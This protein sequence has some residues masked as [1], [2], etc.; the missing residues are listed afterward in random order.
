VGF[1]LSSGTRSN[2]PRH[3][4]PSHPNTGRTTSVQFRLTV[5]LGLEGEGDIGNLQPIPASSLPF[6]WKGSSPMKRCK[7]SWS[8]S[9]SGFAS[10]SLKLTPADFR[11]FAGGVLSIVQP[12]QT[13]PGSLS[14]V[15]FFLLVRQQ[16]GM[17]PLQD[18]ANCVEPRTERERCVPVK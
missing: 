5:A 15:L 16:V 9:V 17:V 2:H 13:P 11:N 3:T 6:S 18:G 14:G 7:S 8:K 4:Y 12:L 1:V 10:L